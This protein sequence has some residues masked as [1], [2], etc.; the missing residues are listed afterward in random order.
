[1]P[2]GALWGVL[3]RSGACLRSCRSRRCWW[4]VIGGAGLV[5]ISCGYLLPVM[6][7]G[8][9]LILC[10][11]PALGGLSPVLRWGLVSVLYNVG[12]V[13][14]LYQVDGFAGLLRWDWLGVGGAVAGLRSWISPAGLRL[15]YPRRG[16][17]RISSAG[18]R[19]WSFSGSPA[20]PLYIV[21][22]AALSGSLVPSP[23]VG[24]IMILGGLSAAV[25][26]AVW[27]LCGVNPRGAY[28]LG[29]RRSCC[30]L[31]Y[32]NNI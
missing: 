11:S 27:G 5:S 3:V 2:S 4:G 26:R 15:L 7:S 1:M 16:S 10:G 19:W 17:L 29:Y 12:R 13:C 30:Y 14:C 23:C 31:L 18:C 21:G 28:M 24:G 32:I 8:A 25:L 20:L 6:I 9:G 22:S